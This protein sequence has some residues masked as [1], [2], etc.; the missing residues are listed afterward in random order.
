LAIRGIFMDL[1]VTFDATEALLASVNKITDTVLALSRASSARGAIGAWAPGQASAREDG[2]RMEA[3]IVDPGAAAPP[4]GDKGISP[5]AAPPAAD[6]AISPKGAPPAAD[7]EISPEAAPPA[8]DKEISP[9]AA[10]SGADK[11]ISSEDASPPANQGIGGAAL[12]AFR[13]ELL[14][15]RKEDGGKEKL[16]ALLA[17]KGLASAKDVAEKDY[18]S[19]L[20]ELRAL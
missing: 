9:E 19:F 20:E 6:K 4:A 11:E 16:Q 7:K 18:Q 15:K 17:S 8:A 5:K 12:M 2:K 1:R 14:E 3:K 13:K 10:P